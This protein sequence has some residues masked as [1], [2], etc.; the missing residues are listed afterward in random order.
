MTARGDRLRYP[1]VV[2]VKD[3][4]VVGHQAAA[5]RL[6]FEFLRLLA[7]ALIVAK[8]L[9]VGLPFALDEGVLNEEV[10]GCGR[11]DPAVVDRSRGHD[12]QAVQGYLLR[13]HDRG[14]LAVPVRL[15]I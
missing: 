10:S 2:E 13:G 15:A 9:V 7:C 4:R 3:G 8:E 14:A 12:R 11:I 6:A 1:P 5:P